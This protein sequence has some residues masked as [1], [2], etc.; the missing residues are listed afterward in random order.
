[1]NNFLAI[2]NFLQ[3]FSENNSRPGLL[4]SSVKFL[5]SLSY[6]I[7]GS[8]PL[9]LGDSTKVHRSENHTNRKSRGMR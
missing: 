7:V 5:D 1:M 8:D 2:S 3:Q 4:R 9:C 6:F